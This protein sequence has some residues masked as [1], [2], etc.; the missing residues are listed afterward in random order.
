MEEIIFTYSRDGFLLGWIKKQLNVE[1]LQHL[2]D[3]VDNTLS[4]IDLGRL[5]TVLLLVVVKHVHE[6][7][8][9]DCCQKLIVFF[10]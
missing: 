5:L 1:I 8:G 6:K 4:A 9:L 2:L 10:K 7:G 3:K